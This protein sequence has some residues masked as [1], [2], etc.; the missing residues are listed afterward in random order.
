MPHWLA[1]AS[2][3]SS[4][5]SPS[6]SA[7]LP[8]NHLV[9][10]KNP[11]R[12][13]TPTQSSITSSKRGVCSTPPSHPSRISS[14]YIIS[15]KS[16]SCTQHGVLPVESPLIVGSAPSTPPFPNP[17]LLN[18]RLIHTQD[19]WILQ[20]SQK[21]SPHCPLP[22]FSSPAITPLALTS[23]SIKPAQTEGPLAEPKP[24]PRS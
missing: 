20:I 7:T 5:T 22:H 24:D 17:N 8:R 12:C 9:P 11:E 13:L 23:P 3:S 1:R 18:H 16:S 2:V 15:S 21:P 6:T 14:K 4:V 19:P 10:R